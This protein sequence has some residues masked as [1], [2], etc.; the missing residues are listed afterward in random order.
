M[1]QNAALVIKFQI[2]W[3]LLPLR[4]LEVTGMVS[5]YTGGIYRIY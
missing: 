5:S 3:A 2:P 4:K 1:A